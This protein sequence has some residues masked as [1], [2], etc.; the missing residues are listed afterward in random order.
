MNPRRVLLV[1]DSVELAEN[2]AEIVGAANFD[3]QVVHSAESA[4][5]LLAHTHFDIILSDLRL[6][7]GSGV[8][9]LRSLRALGNQTPVIL[10]SAFADEAARSAAL[11]LGVR[12]ILVK[13]VECGRLLSEL[14]AVPQN[15][16]AFRGT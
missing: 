8:E 13:P 7:N 12:S 1:E 11:E 5:S 3:A 9:M 6:P 14:E 4:L 16:Q 10:M 15:P 2:L